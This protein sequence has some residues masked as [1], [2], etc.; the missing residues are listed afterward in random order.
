MAFLGV[1]RDVNKPCFVLCGNNISCC[2]TCSTL[3][4]ASCH[5]SISGH[6]PHLHIL[7]HPNL[8]IQQQLHQRNAAMHH[9]SKLPQFPGHLIRRLHR[10]L[11][12]RRCSLALPAS[13]CGK[14]A[15]HQDQNPSRAHAKIA[16]DAEELKI[17]V[18]PDC[19]DRSLHN[20]L[21]GGTHSSMYVDT[22]VPAAGRCPCRIASMAIWAN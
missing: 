4:I 5:R 11:F 15:T 3:A 6:I 2:A 1:H 9:G 8:L 17:L 14:M 20:T 10:R 21:D 7:W 18:Y 12:R 22:A 13:R 19:E 16:Q